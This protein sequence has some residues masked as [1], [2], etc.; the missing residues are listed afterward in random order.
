MLLDIC[1]DVL[2][3]VAVVG[4][5][6]SQILLFFCFRFFFQFLVSLRFFFVSFV[7]LRRLSS[8]FFLFFFVFLSRSPRAGFIFSSENNTCQTGSNHL[9]CVKRSKLQE[10]ITNST[11]GLSRNR[12][13]KITESNSANM[14]RI[15]RFF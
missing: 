15:L 5:R 14:F 8:L 3:G 7:A 10:T 4:V 6:E 12:T 13:R 9:S 1:R 2:A 11:Q